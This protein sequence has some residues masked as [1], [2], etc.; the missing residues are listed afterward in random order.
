VGL[1]IA[2]YDAVLVKGR[3]KPPDTRGQVLHLR[4]KSDWIVRLHCRLL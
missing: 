1:F 4:F 3:F 2:E